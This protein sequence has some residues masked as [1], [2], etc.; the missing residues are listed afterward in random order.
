[1]KQQFFFLLLASAIGLHAGT[2]AFAQDKTG[3]IDKVFGWATA[4]GPGCV[5]AV[6]QHGKVIA[7]RA[8]GSADLEREVPITTNTIFDAGS[9]T[10]QFVAAAVLLLVEEKRLSLADDVHTYIPEL[11][12]YKQKIKI[13][14]VLSHTSGLRDWTGISPL[15]GGTTDALTLVLRQRGLAYDKEDGKPMKGC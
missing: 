2:S 12:D 15:A 11:P 6:S 5:C 3:E 1:M 4:T 9:L 8:Y 14:Q 13:D 10:K 7:N